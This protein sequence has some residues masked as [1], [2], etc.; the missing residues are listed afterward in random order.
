MINN[1]TS[2]CKACM[3]LIRLL[4]LN[5]LKWNRRVTVKYVKSA[6]NILADSVSREKWKVFWTNAPRNTRKLPD[7]VPEILM[8]PEKFWI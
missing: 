2:G 1:T 5:C 8:P 3:K 7:E 6:D 4:V